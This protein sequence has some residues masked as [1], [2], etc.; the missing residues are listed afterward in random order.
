M[1]KFKGLIWKDLHTSKVWFIGWIAIIIV[2]YSIG[3]A[4]SK[5]LNE[6]TLPVAFTIMIGVLQFGFLPVIIYSMLRLEG[7]T[8]LWLH[9]PLSGF[10]LLTSK[11]LVALIY[12]LISLVLVNLLGFI[13]IGRLPHIN[14]WPIKEGVILNLVVLLVGIYF[15]GWIIFFWVSYHYMLKFP[16]IKNVR[17]LIISLFWILYTSALTFLTNLEVVKKLT[18]NYLVVNVPASF[19]FTIGSAGENNG[20]EIDLIPL[21]LIPFIWEGSIWILL[22]II[23][24]RLLDSRIEV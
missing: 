2:M 24:C 1:N 19:F 17:W 16:N 6:A 22:F 3:I 23:S 10:S 9:S 20:F 7:K 11:F 15:S 8:Q 13:S 4:A 21:P 14:Y 5:Y 12:L 18:D